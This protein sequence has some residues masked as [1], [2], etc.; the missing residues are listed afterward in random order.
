MDYSLLNEIREAL[1]AEGAAGVLAER[2][3]AL[4]AADLADVMERLNQEERRSLFLLLP[5]EEAGAV[6]QELDEAAAAEVLENLPAERASRL[7]GGIP[8]DDAADLLQDLP[9]Q[10]ADALLAGMARDDARAVRQL[11]EYPE[12]TAG[13]RMTTE[14]ATVSEDATVAQVIAGLRDQPPAAE[15]GYYLYVCDS[16]E[17]LKGVVSLRDLIVAAPEARI[18]EIMAREVVSVPADADQEEAADLV[19]RYDLLALPV[20]DADQRLVG[21]IT[22]DDVLEVLEEEATEDILGLAPGSEPSPARLAPSLRARLSRAAAVL[23][24]GLAAAGLVSPGQPGLSVRAPFLLFLP[25]VLAVS[26]VV[27]AQV[28][29]GVAGAFRR[30]L[31]AAALARAAGRELVVTGML[32]GGAGLAVAALLGRWH[33]LGAVGADLGAAVFL[34]A[35]IAAVIGVAAPILS[36]LLRH[37]PSAAPVSLVAALS[38]VVGVATYLWVVGR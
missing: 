22:V 18:G 15:T 13:G 9:D 27:T 20:V 37:D 28:M 16:L 35:L 4:R 29:A 10:A 3:Q 5:D 1:A 11:M 26:E 30:E 7:L 36:H 38:A 25:L 33:G 21:V 19:A 2:L 14:F 23:L 12:T 6:L 34:V 17:R 8:S 31:P 32:A 24:A